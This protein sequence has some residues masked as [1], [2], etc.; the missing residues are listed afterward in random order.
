MVVEKTIF[1][2]VDTKEKSSV[3]SKTF[4]FFFFDE[5]TLAVVII[6]V[7]LRLLAQN[8]SI[9]TWDINVSFQFTLNNGTV[10]FLKLLINLYVFTF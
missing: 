3:V 6:F 1:M 5:L 2:K 9:L 8:Q 4:R 10:R 7:L